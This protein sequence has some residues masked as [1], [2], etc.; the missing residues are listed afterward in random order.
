MIF[1]VL[2]VI[3]ISSTSLH[4]ARWPSGASSLAW[5]A[6]CV[7]FHPHDIDHAFTPLTLT[8][9]PPS[10]NRCACVMLWSGGVYAS[11][12]VARPP[13]TKTSVTERST[14]TRTSTPTWPAVILK[15]ADQYSG[16]RGFFG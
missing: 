2:L 8:A 15:G 6:Q 14:N 4:Y 12:P 10:A 11:R 16:H 9:V 3:S 1:N 7:V 13:W 5:T